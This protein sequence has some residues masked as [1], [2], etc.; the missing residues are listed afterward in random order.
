DLLHPQL[1][2]VLVAVLYRAQQDKAPGCLASSSSVVIISS[3]K[4]SSCSELEPEL[5]QAFR[6]HR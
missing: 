4:S 1:L 3:G 5:L 6:W 2:Q